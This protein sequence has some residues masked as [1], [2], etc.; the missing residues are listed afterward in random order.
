MGEDQIIEAKAIIGL[1]WT[2]VRSSS[3]KDLF[4]HKELPILTNEE[5][6]RISKDM[7]VSYKSIR[8]LSPVKSE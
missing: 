3:K 2:K 8:K 5:C 4:L 1:A 7:Q 6:Y